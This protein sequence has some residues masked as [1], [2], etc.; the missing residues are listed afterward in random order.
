MKPSRKIEKWQRLGVKKAETLMGFLLD[1]FGGFRLAPDCRCNSR[2]AKKG[3]IRSKSPDGLPERWR[4]V[5]CDDYSL[6]R[7]ERMAVRKLFFVI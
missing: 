7:S 3:R 1:F 6:S 5:G 4:C 2:L